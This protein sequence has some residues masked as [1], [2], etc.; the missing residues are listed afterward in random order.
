MLS[1]EPNDSRRGSTA[2]QSSSD[3]YT[4]HGLST[5]PFVDAGT[6]NGH[7][8][9]R[10]LRQV[11]HHTVPLAQS[12]RT[13]PYWPTPSASPVLAATV[14]FVTKPSKSPRSKWHGKKPRNQKAEREYLNRKDSAYEYSYLQAEVF[15]IN[16]NMAKLAVPMPGK[17]ALTP[18]KSNNVASDVQNPLLYNK[19]D[20]LN[21]STCALRHSRELFECNL[22]YLENIDQPGALPPHEAAAAI[23]YAAAHRGCVDFE[24]PVLLVPQDFRAKL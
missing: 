2:S 8:A 1:T 22:H 20:M 7:V 17:T 14:P 13:H 23:R 24:L 3:S 9:N 4:G 6:A 19:N 12:H 16:P 21:T 10:R 15:E 11:Y 18:L 5:S